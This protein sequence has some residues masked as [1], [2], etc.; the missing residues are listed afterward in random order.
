VELS[1]IGFVKQTQLR[2]F[3][4]GNQTPRPRRI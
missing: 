2:A 4:R 1:I 3:E